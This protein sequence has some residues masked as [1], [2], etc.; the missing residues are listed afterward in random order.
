MSQNW[1]VTKS[2]VTAAIKYLGFQVTVTKVVNGEEGTVMKA[3]G[4]WDIN[5]KLNLPQVSSNITG[6]QK[7]IYIAGT[8]KQAPVPGDL[9][10]Q[11]QDVW[12]VVEAEAYKP[13][14][15]ILAYRVVVN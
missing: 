10:K 6:N 5:D 15:L 14:A 12:S 9:I 4:C 8:L 3:W 2:Q 11:G 7:Q 1:E 13:A